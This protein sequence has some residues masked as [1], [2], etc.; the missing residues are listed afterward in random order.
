MIYGSWLIY[1]RNNIK[2]TGKDGQL[3]AFLITSI[4]EKML[5]TI[6]QAETKIKMMY[7]NENTEGKSTYG[8][9][10]KF[11]A[12]HFQEAYNRYGESVS[13]QA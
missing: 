13:E 8:R 2:I 4:G 10:Y 11:L 7:P 3:V 5:S 6:Q 9:P 1:Y 12:Q